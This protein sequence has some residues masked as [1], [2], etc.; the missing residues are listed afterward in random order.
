M[1]RKHGE[2]VEND[3]GRRLFSFS[4]ENEMQVM[5]TQYNHKRIHV[6]MPR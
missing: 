4:A 3:S 1:I 5:N 6:D 2:E